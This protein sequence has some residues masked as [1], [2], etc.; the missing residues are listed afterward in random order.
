MNTEFI[1]DFKIRL[2]KKTY[3]TINAGAWANVWFDNKNPPSKRMWTTDWLRID[4]KMYFVPE[5]EKGAGEITVEDN[6]G[7][8]GSKQHSDGAFKSKGKNN[9][10]PRKNAS[11]ETKVSSITISPPDQSKD[12]K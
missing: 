9:S 7:Q 2:E 12:K 5:H 11:G 3:W 6:I 8:N 4:N 10:R 1:T